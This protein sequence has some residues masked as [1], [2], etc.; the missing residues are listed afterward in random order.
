[1]GA[2][3]PWFESSHGAEDSGG[4]MEAAAERASACVG[5]LRSVRGAYV[6][7]VPGAWVAFLVLPQWLRV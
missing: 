3:L 5:C 4:W 6:T 2:A 1:M 7:V